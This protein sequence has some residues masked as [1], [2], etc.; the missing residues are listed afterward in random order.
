[1]K[2]R[3]TTL[4]MM[5]MILATL[6]ACGKIRCTPLYIF[7]TA[8]SFNDSLVYITDIQIIDSAWIDDKNGFLLKRNEYSNQLRNHFTRQGQ[9]SR[10]CQVTFATNEKDILKKYANLRKKLAGTKKH[11]THADIRE[12][13]EEEFTFSSVRPDVF[14]EEEVSTS[15]SKKAQKRAEKSKNKK[16]RGNLTDSVRPDANNGQENTPPAMPPR[17]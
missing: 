5:C 13:D 4:L 6:P 9:S 2:K 15:V 12:I 3:L 7:G 11:P 16:S 17:H 10:T 14:Y 8:T 1:M